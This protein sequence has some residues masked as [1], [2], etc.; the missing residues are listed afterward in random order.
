MRNGQF[1][2]EALEVIF[3]FKLGNEQTDW[4][5][6]NNYGLSETTEQAT[7]LESETTPFSYKYT[8]GGTHLA[9]QRFN[10]GSKEVYE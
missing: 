10:D 6:D 7:I 5:N 4:M 3:Y 1:F 8:Q 2:K 9:F